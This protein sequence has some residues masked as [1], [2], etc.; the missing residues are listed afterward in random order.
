MEGYIKC[1]AIILWILLSGKSLSG[2]SVPGVSTNSTIPSIFF[3][4]TIFVQA[5]IPFEKLKVSVYLVF[6]SNALWIQVI[7]DVPVVLFPCPMFPA[8][9]TTGV[10]FAFI[11][12]HSKGYPNSSIA[13]KIYESW[14]SSSG[15]F[16]G[17][18]SI[19]FIIYFSTAG[20]LSAY[21]NSSYSYSN[22][23]ISDSASGIGACGPPYPDD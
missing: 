7:I 15:M 21:F 11:L 13:L 23:M 19:N 3:D 17:L 22:T 5:L 1:S 4:V 14:F 10:I 20:S 12:F 6:L 8:M 16:V 18:F 2:S 9:T